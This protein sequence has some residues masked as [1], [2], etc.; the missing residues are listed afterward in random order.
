MTANLLLFKITLLVYFVATIC[1]LIGVI[2]RKEGFRQSAV[3][4]LISGFGVHC[5][6]IVVRWCS[7]G[8]VPVASMHESLS[9]FA[10]AL[11]GTYLLF[12]W[13]YRTVMLGAFITPLALSLMIIGTNQS[14]QAP[15]LNP[16]LD[17]CGFRY[18]SPWL[19]WAT[20]SLRL[21][22]PQE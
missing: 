12:Y 22:L 7:T 20:R 13:R 8:A 2:S 4:I 18:T 9:F 19:F 1:Y 3:W 11:I 16:M 10:W 17:S 15:A 5:V 21:Q 14:T 6:T